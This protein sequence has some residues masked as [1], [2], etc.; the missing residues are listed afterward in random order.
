MPLKERLP[1]PTM[2]LASLALLLVLAGTGGA[3]VAQAPPKGS[4]NTAQLKDNA[5]TSP[6][7]K[8]SAVVAGKIAS[9]AVT[10]AKIASNAVTGAKIAGNAV[11]GAKVQDGSLGAADFA[12]G[13][14]PP[15]DAF[16]RFLNG[17]IAV[18]I[19]ATTIGSLTIPQAGSYVVLGK[20]YFTS[21]ALAGTVTCRLEAGTNFDESQTRAEPDKPSTMSLMVLNTFAAAGSVNLTCSANVPQQANFIKITGLRVANLTNTG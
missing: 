10:S 15:S 8:G 3:A 6:K 7:I 14:V 16:G 17:P 18:P 12:A 19:S 2:V 9:N 5:V 20:A 4:V 11:T 13:V 21:G 1:S